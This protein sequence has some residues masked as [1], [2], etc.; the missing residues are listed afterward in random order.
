M[1]PFM[2]IAI[3]EAQATKAEG[4]QPF[5]SVL[6]RGAS[7]HRA[8]AQPLAPEQRPAQPR[9]DGGDQRRWPAGELRRYRALYHLLPPA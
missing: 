6:V 9:R 1:D 3:E 8:R 2:Q 5:G 7:R 4:G